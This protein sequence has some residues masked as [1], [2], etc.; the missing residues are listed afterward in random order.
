MPSYPNSTRY[1]NPAFNDAFKRAVGTIDYL[2][3][4]KHYLDAERIVMA[5]APV[6]PLFY[7]R[8]YRLLQPE[9]RNHPLDAMAHYDMKYVWLDR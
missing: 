6:M 8:H 7:E 3:R 1:N 4:V 9:V 5:D 2:A